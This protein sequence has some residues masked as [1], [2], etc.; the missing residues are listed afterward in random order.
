MDFDDVNTDKKPLT[1][2]EY[3]GKYI[4]ES[5]LMGFFFGVGHFLAYNV[6]RLKLFADLKMLTKK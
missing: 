6:L 3:F 4:F 2:G 5:V 1:W